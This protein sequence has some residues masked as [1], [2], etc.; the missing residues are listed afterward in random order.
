MARNTRKFW[1][2]NDR[3]RDGEL[4][5]KGQELLDRIL[6]DNPDLR[7][8]GEAMHESLD[9]LRGM[10]LESPEAPGLEANILRSLRITTGRERFQY[11]WPAMLAACLAALAL[12]GILQAFVSPTNPAINTRD[13]EARRMNIER[14][15]YPEAPLDSFRDMTP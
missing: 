13:Q 12:V 3:L 10:S 5:A 2:L 6:A 15:L 7:E 8:E 14:T 11:W 4:D 9:L 1:E